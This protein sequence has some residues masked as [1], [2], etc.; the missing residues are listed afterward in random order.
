MSIKKI[1]KLK[2]SFQVPGTIANQPLISDMSPSPACSS[3]PLATQS[4]RKELTDQDL[5]QYKC[6]GNAWTS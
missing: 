3:A 6:S 2:K 5:I 4:P 1:K